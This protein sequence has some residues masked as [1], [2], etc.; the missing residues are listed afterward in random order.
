MAGLLG[1]AVWQLNRVVGV[2]HDQGA[3]LGAEPANGLPALDEDFG[4]RQRSQELLV[5]PDDEGS[6]DRGEGGAGA[7]AAPRYFQIPIV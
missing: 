1:R 3:A 2:C 4:P 5:Q 6:G 7:A